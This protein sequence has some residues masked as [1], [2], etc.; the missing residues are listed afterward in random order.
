VALGDGIGEA[1]CVRLA[2]VLIGER[3]GL[4]VAVV[5]DSV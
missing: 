4:T 3:R 2:V 5:A 1:L